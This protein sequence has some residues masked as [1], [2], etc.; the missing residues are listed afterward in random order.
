[1]AHE[2]APTVK[3]RH[4]DRQGDT[5]PRLLPSSSSG[6]HEGHDAPDAVPLRDRRDGRVAPGEPCS[7]LDTRDPVERRVWLHLPAAGSQHGDRE[8][9]GPKSN[10][11]ESSLSA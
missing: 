11:H 6:V 4:Y 1:M 2:L 8:P 3:V 7:D 9:D 10:V 5:S